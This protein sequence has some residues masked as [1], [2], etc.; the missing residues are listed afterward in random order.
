M[1]D[2]DKQMDEFS[3]ETD[4]A[5]RMDCKTE[6]SSLEKYLN[7]QFSVICRECEI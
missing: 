3:G 6:G 5:F 1:E 7:F 2:K 4:E